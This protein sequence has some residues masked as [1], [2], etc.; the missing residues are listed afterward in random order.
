MIGTIIRVNNWA[1]GGRGKDPSGRL[2]LSGYRSTVLVLA[3]D[4]P[5]RRRRHQRRR[6]PERGLDNHCR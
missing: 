1:C 2:Y 3:L 4:F 6:R 5:I